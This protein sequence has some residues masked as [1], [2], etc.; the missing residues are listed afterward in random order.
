[1]P[2]I[3]EHHNNTESRKKLKNGNL[4]LVL[5]YTYTVSKL[6]YI[7]KLLTILPSYICCFSLTVEK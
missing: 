1:M 2:Q 5:S 6:A 4:F 3:G 7:L